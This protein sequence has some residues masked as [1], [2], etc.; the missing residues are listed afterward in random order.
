MA[1]ERIRTPVS[2]LREGMFISELDRPWHET[3][4]PL[5]GFY[6]RSEDEIRKIEKFC[7]HVFVDEVKSRVE[8]TYEEH[9]TASPQARTPSFE[10]SSSLDSKATS[11]KPSKADK[12][13][14]LPPLTIKD[15]CVYKV[16]SSLQKEAGK[17]K[18]LH[19][20]VQESV[21][22]ICKS[23][24]SGEQISVE[25][26]KSL[27]SNM[28]ASVIRNPDALVWLSKMD[29]QDEFGFR[30]VVRSSIWALVFAR[31]LGLSEGLM[32]ALATGVLLCHVG[33]M[34]IEPVLR[35][36]P[37]MLEGKSLLAYQKY[38]E[39]GLEEL[40]AKA[41]LGGTVL[42]VVEFHAERHNGSGFPKGVTGEYIPLLAKIAGLVDE[43]QSL[44]TPR[45]TEEGLS[46]QGAVAALYEQRN[47][48]FQ[49]DLV[50]RFIEAIG[51]YPIGT[52]VLL[53]TDEVG[54]VTENNTERRLQPTIIIV[55]DA[56]KELL[57]AGRK[58]DLREWNAKHGA[59]KAI[60]I[61]DSLPKGAFG[62]DENSFLLSGATSRWSIKHII[63][64]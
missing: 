7:R 56:E 30:H 45:G 31:H 35:E 50:E 58:L 47:T 61:K 38:V 23:I 33:K 55:T 14:E 24:E 53:N 16:T 59:T 28:V 12:V 49:K 63:G 41:D 2:Q 6:I 5:Q 15:P 4:F 32:E 46:P 48:A 42:S 3:P 13:V 10:D 18:K 20:Q 52:L 1:M 29:D 21:K 11:K 54:I 62:I 57:K 27:A 25:Q 37:S 40:E 39:I 26:T 19:R 36:N 8:T 9:A 64:S 17:I 43:Y 60:R 51:V 22:S 44:I 34:K